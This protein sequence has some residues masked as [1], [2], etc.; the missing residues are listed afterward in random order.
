M[1]N[2]RNILIIAVVTIAILL[3]AACLFVL[4]SN[5]GQPEDT[6]VTNTSSNMDTQDDPEFDE[7]Q[8]NAT[9]S[10]N[11]GADTIV[12]VEPTPIEG[13]SPNDQATSNEGTG[14][15]SPTA[16]ADSQILSSIDQDKAK[17]LA[18]DFVTQ[19]LTY[20]ATSLSNGQYKAGIARFVA[21]DTNSSALLRQHLNDQW[22][23]NMGTYPEVYS[24]L[25]DVAVDDVYVS[26]RDS[27]P[28]VAVSLTCIIDENQ[29][30]P[31]DME[32]EYVNTDRV[33]YAVYFNQNL[34]VID[35]A[36]QDGKTLN[37]NI[38]NYGPSG[39]IQ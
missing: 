33:H 5:S 12:E 30:V 9:T 6:V 35:V 4:F 34:Q 1:H 25:T 27:N 8:F 17:Q 38:F 19:F 20:D 36:R 32:W 7:G 16:F 26:R 15:R 14:M 23:R 18:V 37:F 21:S 22:S 29:G 10:E 2:K 28:T 24:R 31:G 13:E 3:V 11:I 39:I